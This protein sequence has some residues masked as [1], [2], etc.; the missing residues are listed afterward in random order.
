MGFPNRGE[1]GG[2]PIWEKFPHFPVFFLDNV[3]EVSSDLMEVCSALQC[4]D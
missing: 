3:P 4:I 2:F 1:G